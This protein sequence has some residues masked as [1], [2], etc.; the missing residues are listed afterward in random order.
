M[1]ILNVIPGKACG[2]QTEMKYLDVLGKY[3]LN[4]FQFS[5]HNCISLTPDEHTELRP[6]TVV[7]DPVTFKKYFL[8]L[9]PSKRQNEKGLN[10]SY[11]SHTDFR[12]GKLP[13]V[14]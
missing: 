7:K 12:V 10:V 6:C 13:I 4:G 2:L 3:F 5:D 14:E 11:K 8:D 1:P 9:K